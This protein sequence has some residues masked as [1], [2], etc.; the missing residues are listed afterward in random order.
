M[1]YKHKL[2]INHILDD[3]ERGYIKT[4]DEYKSILETIDKSQYIEHFLEKFDESEEAIGSEENEN[5][6]EDEF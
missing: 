2:R 3:L 6:P 1:A 4:K 5:E